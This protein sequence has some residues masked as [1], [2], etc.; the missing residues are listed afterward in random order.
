MM[1]GR[2]A[3]CRS[4]GRGGVMLGGWPH[5]GVRGAGGVKGLYSFVFGTEVAIHKSYI[6][7]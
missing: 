6:C 4:E 3:A 7:S 5:K 2:V 1:T